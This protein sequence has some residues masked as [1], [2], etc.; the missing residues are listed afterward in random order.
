MGLRRFAEE[1]RGVSG[2]T[3]T[4]NNTHLELGSGLEDALAVLAVNNIDESIGVVEIVAPQWAQ[5]LLATDIPHREDD[6]F[7]L[8]FFDVEPWR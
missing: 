6:V 5:L 3:L 8:H 7:V 4:L 2:H 1:G